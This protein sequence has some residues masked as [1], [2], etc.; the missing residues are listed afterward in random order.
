LAD[1]TYANGWHFRPWDQ[2]VRDRLQALL[3][4]KEALLQDLRREWDEIVARASEPVSF[5]DMEAELKRQA[6]EREARP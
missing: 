2:Q 3:R 5:D 4:R 1:G 6:R